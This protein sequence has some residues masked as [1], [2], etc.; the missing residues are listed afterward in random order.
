MSA[1]RSD[2]G[3]TLINYP[4]LSGDVLT[5]NSDVLNHYL[6]LLKNTKSKFFKFLPSFLDL[7][8]QLVIGVFESW[9]P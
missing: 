4:S 8:Q 2:F 7:R 6:H 3:K 5:T 1:T 9:F